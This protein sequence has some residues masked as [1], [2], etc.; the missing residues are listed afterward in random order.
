[1]FLSSFPSDDCG[2]DSEINLVY[3][4]LHNVCMCALNISVPI[5]E[6]IYHEVLLVKDSTKN[7]FPDFPVFLTSY[8]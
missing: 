7:L 2:I 5:Q 1:M 3:N 4:R 8:L 6:S